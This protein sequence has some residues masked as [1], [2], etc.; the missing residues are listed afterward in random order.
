MFEGMNSV[1]INNQYTQYPL[2]NIFNK[3]CHILLFWN[4]KR[5][6]T[7]NK[8][9]IFQWRA[10]RTLFLEEMHFYF[11]ICLLLTYTW[12]TDNFSKKTNEMQLT[13]FWACS[14]QTNESSTNAKRASKR[15]TKF[16]QCFLQVPLKKVSVGYY[17]VS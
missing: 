6:P 10:I 4:S 12:K 16:E 14:T 9:K 3:F 17:I 15:Q 7:C 1:L 8:N 2:Q 13:L 11:S 5:L